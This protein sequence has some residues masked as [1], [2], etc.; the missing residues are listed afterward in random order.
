[1]ALSKAIPVVFNTLNA[2]SSCSACCLDTPRISVTLFG[3]MYEPFAAALCSRTANFYKIKQKYRD[4]GKE[5]W[6][7]C[8]MESIAR[9][10][11]TL[12]KTYHADP[13][14]PTG[15]ANPKAGA[16]LFVYQNLIKTA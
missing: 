12:L 3:L 1:M 11:S 10:I 9:K 7:L 5:L 4:G 13:G 15:G 14:F 2:S 8:G 6:K 16:N